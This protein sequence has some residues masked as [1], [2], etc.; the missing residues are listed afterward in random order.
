MIIFW[1]IY[2]FLS[3]VISF[4]LTLLSRNRNIKILVFSLSMALFSSVWFKNPGENAIAPVISIFLLETTI[5][6]NNGFSRLLRP[7]GLI[8]FFLILITFFLWKKKSKS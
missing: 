8:S 7:I 5:L 4:L 1:L 3:F 2:F 6:E